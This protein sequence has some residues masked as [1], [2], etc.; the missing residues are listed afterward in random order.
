M[1]T[2]LRRKEIN[3]GAMRDDTL[4]PIEMSKK[5]MIGEKNSPTETEYS[6]TNAKFIL[7]SA[8]LNAI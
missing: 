7:M 5:M 6:L 8:E 2:L 1:R 4:K 3:T